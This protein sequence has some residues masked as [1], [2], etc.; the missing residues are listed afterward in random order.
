MGLEA[1]L[2]PGPGSLL[3]RSPRMHE[4]AACSRPAPSRPQRDS[5]PR[6]RSSAAAGAEFRRPRFV[7]E[8]QEK[9]S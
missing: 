1:I 7:G 9:N 3:P 6:R 5:P 2:Q 4:E 8:K